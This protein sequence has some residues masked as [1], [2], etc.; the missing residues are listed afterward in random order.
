MSLIFTCALVSFCSHTGHSM[1]RHAAVSDCQATG[2]SEET[3]S[4]WVTDTV[5]N[6]W[7]SP[8]A[9]ETLP[10]G[11]ATAH[12][13]MKALMQATTVSNAQKRSGF[14]VDRFLVEIVAWLVT[15]QLQTSCTD[16]CVSVAG[17]LWFIHLVACVKA[18]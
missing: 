17:T 14:D 3:L 13:I 2:T 7:L 1:T 5:A 10:C 18:A 11:W 6:Q 16:T 15:S 12:N 8:P 9:D 4:G